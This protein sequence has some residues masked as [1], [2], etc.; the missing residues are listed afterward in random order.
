MELFCTC[1]CFQAVLYAKRLRNLPDFK[2][3]TG[4]DKDKL[5]QMGTLLGSMGSRYLRDIPDDKVAESIDVFK[6]LELSRAEVHLILYKFT[7]D[8]V[9]SLLLVYMRDSLAIIMY[10]VC[11]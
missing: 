5:A 8:N 7:I 10:I 11:Y 1:Q 3:A 6:N 2:N 4:L 9:L